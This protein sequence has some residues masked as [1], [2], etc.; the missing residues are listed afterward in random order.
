MPVAITCMY[1]QCSILDTG[2]TTYGSS[3]YPF[4]NNMLL[5]MIFTVIVS[6]LGEMQI[7]QLSGYASLILSTILYAYRNVTKTATDSY[8]C[9]II[10]TGRYPVIPCLLS[11]CFGDAIDLFVYKTSSISPMHHKSKQRR[12]KVWDDRVVPSVHVN[13]CTPLDM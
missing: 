3:I 4:L 9:S 7:C 1:L 12:Q 11:V 6:L 13:Q 2:T 10:N 5:F 8:K